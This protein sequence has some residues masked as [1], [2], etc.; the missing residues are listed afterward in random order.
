[1]TNFYTLLIVTKGN[2]T[3]NENLDCLVIHDDF[4]FIDDK[5][6]QVN[7]II[8]EFNY[9]IFSDD[10][11]FT[12]SNGAF[13]ILEN[14]KPIVNFERLTSVE[15]LYYCKPEEIAEIVQELEEE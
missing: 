7:N 5:H 1:M 2:Y 8:Y 4:C 6:I 10:V 3:P 11:N 15:G 12:F 13:M 9:L 14:N